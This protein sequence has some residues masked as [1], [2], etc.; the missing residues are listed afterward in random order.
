MIQV[1]DLV[2]PFYEVTPV[3][4]MRLYRAL[5]N[6]VTELLGDDDRPLIVSYAQETLII[7]YLPYFEQIK[8]AMLDCESDIT[9]RYLE[10]LRER[11]ERELN[12]DMFMLRL[13][14]SMLY[15]FVL[16]IRQIIVSDV[17]LMIV[18]SFADES[19]KNTWNN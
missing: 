14:F 15:H 10:P 4:H 2:I 8:T 9:K 18:T 13:V 12:D 6:D 19:E 1:A 3:G 11:L 5:E 7:S 16:L 17:T